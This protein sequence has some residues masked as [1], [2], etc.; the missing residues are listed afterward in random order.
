MEYTGIIKTCQKIGKLS[1]G[2]VREG[3]IC[4]ITLIQTLDFLVLWQNKAP[5]VI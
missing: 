4:S 2:A 3:R 1:V 5:A